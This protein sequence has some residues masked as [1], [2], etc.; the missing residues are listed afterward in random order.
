MS[1]FKRSARFVRRL[2]SGGYCSGMS[3]FTLSRIESVDKRFVRV[4]VESGRCANGT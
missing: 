1:G 4:S 3:G 2:T